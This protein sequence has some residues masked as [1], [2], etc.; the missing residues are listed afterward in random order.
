MQVDEDNLREEDQVALV[1]IVD[2]GKTIMIDDSKSD[3]NG[4]FASMDIPVE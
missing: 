4:Q 3:D 1:S 2:K